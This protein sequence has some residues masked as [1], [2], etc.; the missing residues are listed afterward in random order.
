MPIQPPAIAFFAADDAD[1]GLVCRVTGLLGLSAGTPPAGGLFLRADRDGLA[2]V[3]DGQVLRGDFARLLPRTLPN[4]LNGELLVRA[5]RRKDG[6]THPT[7]VDATAGLGEDAF[8]LAAAGFTVTMFERDP[9]I[10]ALLD[11][12]LRRGA[13]NP[14]LAPILA[15]MTLRTEDSV[16]AL[17]H[18]TPPPDVIVLDPMFPRRQKSGSIKKKFQLLQQ[19]EQPC[20]EEEALLSAALA[21][22][23]GRIVIKRP[24]KGPYLAGIRPSHSLQGGSV[25]YDCIVRAVK[26]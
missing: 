12:A 21:C 17:P 4:N 5:A 8:L 19:L 16:A 25:R 20:A 2:L 7:A 1:P 10:A 26:K 13:D 15:R 6:P 9:I 14:A 3:A 23:P 11:D 22:S 18:L 24:G